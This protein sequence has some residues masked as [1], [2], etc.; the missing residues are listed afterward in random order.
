M[1]LRFEPLTAGRW[2]DLERLFG[3]R[4]ACGGCWCMSWRKTRSEFEKGKGDANRAA[5]KA[6]ADTGA[7][8]G[9]LAYD[10]AVPVGWC[11]IAPREAYIALERSRVLRRLDDVP[12]WSVSCLFVARGYRNRGV[13]AGLLRAA[14][15]FAGAKGASVVEGYPMAP[16]KGRMPDAFVWTGLLSA[17][18]KAGFHEMPRWSENRPIVRYE[19]TPAAGL[20]R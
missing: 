6:L 8:P 17:F 13:S 3:A 11:A 1:A 7:E 4:G 2:P 15:G 14:A 12:V 19:V 20:L 5:L 10:G 9:I 16:K 18:L